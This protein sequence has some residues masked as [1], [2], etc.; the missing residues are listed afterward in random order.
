MEREVLTLFYLCELPLAEVA[1][2]LDVPLGTAKS[3]LFRARRMLGRSMERSAP[4]QSPI[5]TPDR[6]PLTP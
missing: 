6:R 1:S 5:R 4:T 3:R 2:A